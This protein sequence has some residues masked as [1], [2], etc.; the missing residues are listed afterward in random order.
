[1]SEIITAVYENG[2]LRP[3]S[4]LPLQEHQTV[5]I[6]VLTEESATDASEVI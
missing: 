1:M 2:M 4:P 5:Q 6:Q 3:L